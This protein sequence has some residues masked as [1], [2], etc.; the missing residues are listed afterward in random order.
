MSQVRHDSRIHVEKGDVHLRVSDDKAIKLH[1][2]ANDVIPDAKFKAL[3][4]L[5]VEEDKR[6]KRF[7]CSVHPNEFA[8]ELLV[9]AEDGNVILESQDWASSLGLKL[10]PPKTQ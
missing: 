2:E 8:A 10:T 3:G 7:H 9:V 6:R 1:I 4:K 5:T